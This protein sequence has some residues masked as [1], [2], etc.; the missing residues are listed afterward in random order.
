M[1]PLTLR[2]ISSVDATGTPV[3]AHD[4]RRVIAVQRFTQNHVGQQAVCQP[5]TSEDDAIVALGVLQSE[6]DTF[7]TPK[8]VVLQCGEA[9]LTLTPDGS[10][11]LEGSDFGVR[12][13]DGVSINGASIDL[14]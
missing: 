8:P 14:N 12:V 10:I 3:L 2:H 6:T 11:R 13:R 1:I 9:R 4:N 7:D 5:V